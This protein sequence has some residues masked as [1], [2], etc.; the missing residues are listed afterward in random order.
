MPSTAQRWLAGIALGELHAEVV[1][2]SNSVAECWRPFGRVSVIYNGVPEPFFP[3][4]SRGEGPPRIGC[5]GRISPEKGHLA[6]LRAALSIL[7]AIPDARFFVYGAALFGD[8]AAGQYEKEVRAAAKDM[9]VEFRGWVDDVDEAFANLDLLLVPSV[10]QE[11]NALVILEAFA[12]GVP[13]IA[14]R[15]GGIP[16]FLDQVCDTSEEM[17]QLAVGI[18]RDPVRYNALAKSGRESWR[19]NFHPARYRREITEAMLR[20]KGRIA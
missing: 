14:F 17:A 5:I 8:T 16:E 11:P 18:L 1:A 2:V 19:K 20:A 3:E 15:T 13:A 7:E 12:A 9:P 4:P 6:F 10:W